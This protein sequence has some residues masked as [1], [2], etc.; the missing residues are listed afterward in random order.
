MLSPR[1]VIISVRPVHTNDVWHGPAQGQ[2]LRL[3]VFFPFLSHQPVLSDYSGESQLVS[4][5]W[6]KDHKMLREGSRPRCQITEEIVPDFTEEYVDVSLLPQ[7][8]HEGVFVHEQSY[9]R[10]SVYCVDGRL[11][12]G[13]PGH[14]PSYISLLTCEA[15]AEDRR[16]CEE[17]PCHSSCCQPWQAWSQQSRLCVYTKSKHLQG[18]R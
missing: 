2:A 9:Y 15:R 1:T 11:D 18:Y 4:F 10:P 7:L 12:S 13:A 5:K 3:V 17:P 6:L 14:Q 8:T 16:S